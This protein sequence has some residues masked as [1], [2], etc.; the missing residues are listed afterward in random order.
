MN[1]AGEH[2]GAV[3]NCIGCI[4]RVTEGIK[5]NAL[6]PK[7]HAHSQN[8][9]ET[10]H[11]AEQATKRRITSASNEIEGGA[12]PPTPPLVVRCP[13]GSD[14]PAHPQG[15]PAA[16]EPSCCFKASHTIGVGFALTV[17]TCEGKQAKSPPRPLWP[18]SGKTESK[19]R[20]RV[21]EYRKPSL[22]SID[23]A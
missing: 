5:P 13:D 3:S 21:R 23:L 11:L 9:A 12:S 4:R 18:S 10:S 6:R 1:K 8:R 17:S 16:A 2:V 14:C 19:D 15:I 22:P 7:P 20:T